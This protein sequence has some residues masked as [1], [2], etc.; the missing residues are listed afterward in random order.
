MAAIFISYKRENKEAVQPLVQ[1]LRGAGLDVWW[2]QDIAPDAPWEQTIER[3]L[4]A[5]KVVIVAWSQAAVA[6]ENVKAESRR[7]RNQGKLIQTFVEPCEP[8][9]F[10]GERQG[11]DLSNWNGAANDHRF[12]AVLTAARAI[13]AGKKPPAGVGY[14]PKKRAPWATLTAVFV[15]LSA[16]L[17]FVS[18]LGGA[19]DAV[20]SIGAVH[21]ACLRAGLIQ[22]AGPSLAEQQRHLVQAIAGHWA[23]GDRDC[24]TALDYA[25][26]LGDDGR[27]YR[28]RATAP[29]FDSTLQVESIDPSAGL[30]TARETRPGPSGLRQEWQFRPNGDILDIKDQ[31]GTST[32]LARCG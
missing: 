16:V 2:D 26:A 17:G 3:E 6:S 18:N 21:D 11:V 15:F 1:S 28:I 9:L 24:N 14:A 32:P 29:G 12:Q 23:R 13:L 30:V 20:C 27:T 8:P 25:V 4:E 10:F 19:R 22:P 7:A 5:A 31:A